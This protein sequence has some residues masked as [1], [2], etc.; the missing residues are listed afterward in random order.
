M[1]PVPYYH[2]Y[3]DL[4]N[5]YTFRIKMVQYAQQHGISQAA[6]AFATTRKTVRKWLTRYQAQGTPGLH[7]HS[8]APH[9]IP[10]KSPPQVEQ[11]AVALRELLPTWG[12]HRLHTEARVAI[13]GTTCYR[14]WREKGLVKPRRRKHHKKRD[15]R[16]IKKRFAPFAKL[17]QDVKDL[18][19]IPTYWPHIRRLGFPPHQLTCREIRTGATFFA[20]A[21]EN[22]MTN[23]QL[24]Q[25]Y[26][27]EHLKKYGVS[28]T[29]VILQTDNGSEN[30]GSWKKKTP[31]AFTRQVEDHYGMQHDRIPPHCS[32]YNSD[33]ESFHNLIEREFY[34]IETF[35]GLP[36]LLGK[37]YAYQLYFNYQ[38]PNAWREGKSPYELLS[39]LAPTISPQVLALPPVIVDDFLKTL[40]SGGYSDM[41]CLKI[42]RPRANV[43]AVSLDKE[44]MKAKMDQ[45]RSQGGYHL[46]LLVTF[47]PSTRMPCCFAMIA[48]L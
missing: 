42:S 3:R 1:S 14:I 29:D 15:L 21:Y 44:H 31:S 8:K 26:V 30:I 46:P 25:A 32:T 34:D 23:S 37:A 4:R 13:S 7:D 19:D 2:I 48:L 36:E 9:R 17:Q 24:F 35:S 28:L 20:Y 43:K 38:R 12:G 22:T 5:P 6:R 39:E 18:D 11:Q 33:V 27:A 45:N 41:A 47:L 10:H 16:E 40:P